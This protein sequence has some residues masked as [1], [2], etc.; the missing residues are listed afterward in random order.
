M[1]SRL[2]SQ[3]VALGLCVEPLREVRTPLADFFSPLLGGLQAIEPVVWVA[4]GVGDCEHSDFCLELKEHE[5]V[6]ESGEQGTP[7]M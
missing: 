7:D 4:F 5:C 6:G 2:E 3:L 1:Y